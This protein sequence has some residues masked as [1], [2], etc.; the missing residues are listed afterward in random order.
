MILS[1]RFRQAPLVR[2]LEQAH[3]GA[4]LLVHCRDI[5]TIDRLQS[6]A[7][8]DFALD[9]VLISGGPPE[10]ALIAAVKQRG[11]ARIGEIVADASLS[12][13]LLLVHCRPLDLGVWQSIA[14]L[15]S[16]GRRAA[17]GPA[18]CL[19]GDFAEAVPT[20][21]QWLDDGA[22]IGLAACLALAREHRPTPGLIAETADHVAIEC[23][24]G[25]LDLLA[26]LLR[27][28][29]ADRFDPAQWL[30]AQP[31]AA[32]SM[33][34]WRGEEHGCPAALA[35]DEPLALARR[36]WRGQVAV[37]FPWQEF[38][39]Q[40]VL[41]TGSHRLP[42][43]LRDRDT[44]RVIPT[45]DY[46]WSHIAIGLTQTGQTSLAAEARTL[47]DLRNALA[48]GDT[49]THAGAE[50]ARTASARLRSGLG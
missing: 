18:L 7:E 22:L 27:R 28:P 11:H 39:R 43:G 41:A 30:A 25:D 31:A 10:Q 21:C 33:L 23:A 15:W 6:I 16:A 37:L 17:P 29:D 46:E 20:G 36:V 19:V 9:V 38:E 13:T 35:R 50:R 45:A 1:E 48:H 44:D 24:R 2:A 34:S 14:G 4:P 3:D 49:V 42:A 12:H 32:I 26:R 5:Q 40:A 8:R 47:K